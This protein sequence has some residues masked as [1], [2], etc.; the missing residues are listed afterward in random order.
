ME[1]RI[2]IVEDDLKNLK[3]VRD[4]LQVFGYVTLEATNGKQGVEVAKEQKPD[5]IL[6]DIQMPVMD[7]LQ[8]T[9]LLKS[10]E[11]TKKIPIIALTAYAM[12]GDEEKMLQAGCNDYMPKPIDT[13]SFL[14]TK[15]DEIK[16]K[17]DNLV[18]KQINTKKLI[19]V[20]AKSI[21]DV[22]KEL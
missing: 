11:E 6:M 4:L 5:L 16:E 17:I 14:D 19:A 7:G 13:K 20:N 1:K 10:D 9:R 12:K 8:A 21:I 3:L 22:E 15:I 18:K 2:L